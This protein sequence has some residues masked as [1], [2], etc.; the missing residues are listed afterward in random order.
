MRRTP[1][2]VVPSLLTTAVAI[3]WGCGTSEVPVLLVI[4]GGADA[5]VDV[6]AP[7]PPPDGSPPAADAG[8]YC[9]GSGPPV[10]VATAADGGSVSTCP[11]Q[12]AQRAFRYALCTCNNYVSSQA[13]VTDAFDGTQGP[14]DP[15]KAMAGGS[16]GVN[17]DLHPTGPM[18]IGGSLWATN[19][20]AMAA[21]TSAAIVVT[22]DLHAQGE[23]RPTSLT[24]GGDAW[25]ASGIQATGDVHITGT[26]HVPPMEP[27]SVTGMFSFGAMDTASLPYAPAC[28]CDPS[29]FVDVAGVV[30][31]YEA[32]N[33]DDALG[34]SKTMLENVQ[35]DLTMTL[36][37]G[38]I[39]L[40]RVGGA[41]PIH[42]TVQ[43]RVA[44]FVKGDISATDFTI[45]VPP[46]SEL[47]LYVGNN[48]TVSRTFQIGDPNNPARARTYVGG[49][50]VNLQSAATLAGNLYAPGATITLGATAAKTLYGSI[51]AS[52]L[53]S[54]SDLTIHFD[55]AILTPSAT[56]A[57][58]TP[59]ACVTCTDCNGQAC[60]SKTCG[61]CADSSQC[62]APLVC[63]QGTC[64]AGFTPR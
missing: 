39:F 3:G 31:T 43:G 28:E 17:G 15:S 8:A 37:C 29:Q 22:G 47:D 57:C 26:L 23:L 27:S 4:P 20:T 40:T 49:T 35:S 44:L 62:C 21:I 41:A 33:D 11:D 30:R 59:T 16:V 6:A 58:A 48:V 45:D 53:A 63:S 42:L 55:T 18:T 25:L 9:Q 56:P 14:Y 32:Q 46:Q 19:M 10:L 1:R 38:R 24:V 50:S 36:P 64:V 34:L 54:E 13:L 12:L 52:A 60:N 51:F 2:F 5:G 61:Q 7:A